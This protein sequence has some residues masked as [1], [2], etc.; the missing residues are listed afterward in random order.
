MKA[1]QLGGCALLC[2]CLNA[3]VRSAAAEIM[4]GIT[5][6]PNVVVGKGVPVRANDK[7]EYG[8]GIIIG[9]PVKASLK[10][11]I[12]KT[13]EL[14]INQG[15][16]KDSNAYLGA[17]VHLSTDSKEIFDKFQTLDPEKSY[18]FKYKHIHPL[19]PEVE[20]SHLQV[21]GF[22]IPEDYLKQRGLTALPVQIRSGDSHQSTY[23]SGIRRGRIVDVERYGYFGNF[24]SFELNVGGLQQDAEGKSSEALMTFTVLDEDVSLYLES[25]IALGQDIEVAYVQDFIE[26]WQPSDYFCKGLKLLARS[27]PVSAA[28]SGAPEAKPLARDGSGLN[29]IKKQLL[30]DPQFIDALI[31]AMNKRKG[32]GK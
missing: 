23:S 31:D 29:E 32:T 14:E 18:I 12:W 9:R 20:D 30:Q 19:N 28:G 21:V 16:F 2:I 24:C 17:I 26:F 15:G 6:T 5:L 8:G 27:E 13:Y 25:A 4:N 1:W 22:S 3:D 7:N 11:L 10:G